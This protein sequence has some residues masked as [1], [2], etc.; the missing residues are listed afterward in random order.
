MHVGT[1]HR[2]FCFAALLMNFMS[3]ISP[4][5]N[6]FITSK[7]CQFVRGP[8]QRTER[9]RYQGG[10]WALSLWCSR[11][12]AE[13]TEVDSVL[14][15]SDQGLLVIHLASLHR[16]S[17]ATAAGPSYHSWRLHYIPFEQC[18]AGRQ[19]NTVL[20][21]SFACFTKLHTFCSS[22]SAAENPSG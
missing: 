14:M 11:C 19:R 6:V 12:R 10:S 3:H 8:T 17:V 13:V 4:N 21:L 16:V 20:P 18:T 15:T 2:Q 5:A 1:T 9:L 22:K 7:G